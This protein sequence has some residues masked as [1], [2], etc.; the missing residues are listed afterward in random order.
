MPLAIV[1]I[2][3]VVGSIGL[4]GLPPT[5]GFT[6]KF[7]IFAAVLK[8]QHYVL[9]SLAVFNVCISAFYYLRLVRA[10]YSNVEQ[11]TE[12]I[13]LSSAANLL[14]ILIIIAIF[15]GGLLPQNFLSLARD[16]LASIMP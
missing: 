4:A 13:E 12:P 10:A 15:A 3:L 2:L 6:A 1:L 8:Q 5:I 7:I 11:E 9:V 14:G 16:G